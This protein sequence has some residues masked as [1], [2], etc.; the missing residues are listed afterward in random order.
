[1]R[2]GGASRIGAPFRTTYE[3]G[4]RC[5]PQ[6]ESRW[7]YVKVHRFERL[8]GGTVAPQRQTLRIPA[9]PPPT[10]MSRYDIRLGLLASSLTH[11]LTVLSLSPSMRSQRCVTT[12]AQLIALH[13]WSAAGQCL[14]PLLGNCRVGQIFCTQFMS[15]VPDFSR[16]PSG[17]ELYT[18]PQREIISGLI[19]FHSSTFL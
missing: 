18:A 11:S 15:S 2:T 3:T 19:K 5:R 6:D 7:C 13:T 4:V 9:S 16:T 10:Q 12:K 14:D 17:M 1:M 8:S